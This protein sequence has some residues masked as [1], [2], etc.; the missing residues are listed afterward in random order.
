MAG[1]L[2][3]DVKK[4]NASSYPKMSYSCITRNYVGI[5]EKGLYICTRP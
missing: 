1:L 4:I 5:L 2:E 3:A